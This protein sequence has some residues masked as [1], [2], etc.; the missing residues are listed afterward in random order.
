MLILYLLHFL[1]YKRSNQSSGLFFSNFS[2]FCILWFSSI[3]NRSIVF[4]K[5]RNSIW[6]PIYILN[7][8]KI[9]AYTLCFWSSSI[10][11][12]YLFKDLVWRCK[13]DFKPCGYKNRT[14]PTFGHIVI[15]SSAYIRFVSS[16]IATK[17][18]IPLTYKICLWKSLHVGRK[19][20]F[21]S[22]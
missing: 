7:E 3:H 19:F 10:I 4:L 21:P 18:T 14:C 8:L 17:E 2:F 15:S 16:T 20:I 5:K 9:I 12:I 6:K 1:R 13:L 11:P 22:L